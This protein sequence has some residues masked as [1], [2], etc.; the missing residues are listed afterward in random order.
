MPRISPKKTIEGA[1]GGAICCLVLGGIFMRYMPVQ[2]A[3]GSFV[4]WGIVALMLCVL[5]QIGDLVESMFKRSVKLKDSGSILPGH[6][7]MLDRFDG[8][9]FSLPFIFFYFSLL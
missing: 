4:N 8:P 2:L 9:F 1:V 3:S 6:G 5:S 7:G